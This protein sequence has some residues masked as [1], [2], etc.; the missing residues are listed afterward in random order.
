MFVM[1]RTVAVTSTMRSG[2]HETCYRL[3]MGSASLIN[4]NPYGTA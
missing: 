2:C 3:D 4:S 1:T